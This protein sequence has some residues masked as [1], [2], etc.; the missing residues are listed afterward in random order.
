MA[1]SAAFFCAARPLAPHKNAIAVLRPVTPAVP[2][3][4]GTGAANPDGWLRR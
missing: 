2:V 3:R 1:L 4:G